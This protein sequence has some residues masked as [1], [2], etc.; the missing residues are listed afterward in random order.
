[1]PLEHLVL[2]ATLRLL[3]CTT[4]GFAPIRIFHVL[5]ETLKP[6]ERAPSIRFPAFGGF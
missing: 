3:L 4:L 5:L 6:A 1:V 2:R